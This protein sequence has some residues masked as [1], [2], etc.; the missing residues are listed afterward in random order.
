MTTLLIALAGGTGATLRFIVD[1]F[2]GQR[3]RLS[4]PLGTW[5]INTTG[6][7]ALGVM[8]GFAMRDPALGEIAVIIGTGL[9]G[10]YTTFSTASVEG[11]ALAMREGPRAGL[12]AVGH[13][14]GMLGAG[15]LAAA[16][17]LWLALSILAVR[18]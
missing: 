5:V 17:G 8:T 16:G 14:T 2:I 7:F 10:G 12:V 3:N 1:G 11:V 15:L 13:A 9:I 4:V 6:S 18:A